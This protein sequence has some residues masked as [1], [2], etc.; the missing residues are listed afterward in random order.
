MFMATPRVDFNGHRWCCRLLG[1]AATCSVAG[2]PVQAGEPELVSQVRT[3]STTHEVTL[4]FRLSEPG[5]PEV[6]LGP[7]VLQNG[8]CFGR[9]QSQMIVQRAPRPMVEHAATFTGLKPGTTYGYSIVL[10]GGKRCVSGRVNTS[11]C[12][13]T[14]C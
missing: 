13:D 11:V 9:N 1:L 10:K 7:R 14:G 5:A 3:R 4:Q 6:Q 2:S 12:I 8:Q